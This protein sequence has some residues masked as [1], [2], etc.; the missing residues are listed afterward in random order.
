MQ[1]ITLYS[2]LPFIIGFD[3]SHQIGRAEMFDRR[4]SRENDNLYRDA[5][6][7]AVDSI[8]LEPNLTTI[9]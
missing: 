9:Y 5:G 4:I 6:Y 2:C 7:K 3:Y 8:A 1:L